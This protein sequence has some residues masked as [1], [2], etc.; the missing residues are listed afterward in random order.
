MTTTIPQWAIDYHAKITAHNAKVKAAKAAKTAA[1][2][3]TA[4]DET[5]EKQPLT[6]YQPHSEI[7]HG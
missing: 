6:I 3:E 2:E 5:A 1:T 7:N 4:S